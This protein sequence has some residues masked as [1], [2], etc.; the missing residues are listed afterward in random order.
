MVFIN[1]R[2][3]VGPAYRGCGRMEA[4]ARRVDVAVPPGPV[5]VAVAVGLVTP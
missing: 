2:V 5:N 3:V 1:F 4:A